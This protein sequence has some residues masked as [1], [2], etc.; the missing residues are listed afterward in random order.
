MARISEQCNLMA[1]AN[2]SRDGI[3][4]ANFPI[5][6]FFRLSHRCSNSGIYITHQ[7]PHLIHVS[8]SKPRFLDIFGIFV[9]YNPVELVAISKRVLDEVDIVSDPDVDAFFLNEFA[10]EWILF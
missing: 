1:L 4:I 8:W 10:A 6:A 7:L 2:P 5:Q 9:C 3:P